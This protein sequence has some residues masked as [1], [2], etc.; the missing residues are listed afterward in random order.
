MIRVG[1]VGLGVISKFYLAALER[2]PRFALSAVCDPDPAV[3]AGA[4]VPAHRDHRTMLA[5]GGLDAVI[6][7]AP[8][9][10]HAVVAR[11]VLDEG[12]AVCVEKPLATTLAEG[13]DLVARAQRRDV[14]LYTA[15]H[16][17]HNSNV[18]ALLAQL[19]GAPPIEKVQVRYLERIEDHAG[20][21]SWYLDAARC[22]GGCVADNGP[23]ALDLVR[24]ILGT[25]AFEGAE[26]VR[27]ADGVDRR[28]TLF[29][30]RATIELDWSFPGEV[31]DIEVR[32]TDGA[33]LRAD[34]LGGY[35]GFK[36]SL[37]H[38]Y[39]GVL[40]EFADAIPRGGA[41]QDGGPAALSLVEQAYG[42]VAHV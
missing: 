39:A 42:R 36:E 40:R 2:L 21:D 19:A 8:N 7:T 27:D 41:W 11:D 18:R 6:V 17:R 38:E 5:E 22:G 33:V 26:I 3:L 30:D 23:N 4:E 13:C 20:P 28:A 29:L 12:L 31:K 10:V 1:V 25:M 14:A 34:L 32:L 24:Q 9:D 16:R 15:F 35:A 37:W